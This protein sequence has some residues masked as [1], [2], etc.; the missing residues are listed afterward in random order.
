MYNVVTLVL[1]LHFS[2]LSIDYFE[3]YNHILL[4][5]WS[6]VDVGDLFSFYLFL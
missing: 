4:F 5:K 6:D 2:W 1:L 3:H